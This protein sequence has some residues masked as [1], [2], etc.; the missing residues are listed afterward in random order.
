MEIDWNFVEA[1]NNLGLA[2]E[3][4]KDYQEAI[5]CY[6]HQNL[7]ILQIHQFHS[8]HLNEETMIVAQSIRIMIEVKNICKEHSIKVGKVTYFRS[9]DTV[10][11]KCDYR[12]ILT[13]GTSFE[14]KDAFYTLAYKYLKEKLEQKIQTNTLSEKLSYYDAK[15]VFFQAISR[16]E[17]NTDQIVF[18]SKT[19]IKNLR[20]VIIRCIG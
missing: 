6:K 12:R 4:Q 20:I 2:H 17:R 15:S 14:P 1:W 11:V 9:S 8:T 19:R 13:I 3:G 10:G 16:G 18:A 7:Q 5:H